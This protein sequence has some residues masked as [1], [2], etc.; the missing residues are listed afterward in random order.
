MLNVNADTFL[1]ECPHCAMLKAA[2]E[3]AEHPSFQ[4]EIEIV[5]RNQIV[6][7]KSSRE[8]VAYAYLSYG[9]ARAL[10]QVLRLALA[11]NPEPGLR[12]Y[13]LSTVQHCINSK[14]SDERASACMH[15]SEAE[16]EKL[17]A[18]VKSENEAKAKEQLAAAMDKGLN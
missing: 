7:P 8:A 4:K 5:H 16:V 17:V 11:G 12:Q 9:I 18:G 13:I 6:E 2:Q 15:V 3:V 1:D 14:V 10:G